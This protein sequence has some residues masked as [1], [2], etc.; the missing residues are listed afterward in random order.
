MIDR[1]S[2][3]FI[4]VRSMFILIKEKGKMTTCTKTINECFHS[5]CR[6]ILGFLLRREQ[7]LVYFLF[8][9]MKIKSYIRDPENGYA[10]ALFCTYNI[11]LS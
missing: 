9:N 7:R 10:S 5:V 3:A 2:L 6:D 8:C 1:F 4:R 11:V